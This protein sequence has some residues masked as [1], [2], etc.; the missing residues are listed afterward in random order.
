MDLIHKVYDLLGW[1]VA[2]I[3]CASIAMGLV[4]FGADLA[5]A[6]SLQALFYSMNLLPDKPAL[7]QDWIPYDNLVFVLT[8]FLVSGTGRG[9]VTWAQT[10]LTGIVI[11]DFESRIRSKLINWAFADR[12]V[13]VGAIADLFN[14]KTIGASNFI[15]SLL[16]SVETWVIRPFFSSPQGAIRRR[17]SLWRHC[18]PAIKVLIRCCWY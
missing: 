1:R 7:F 14:D 18:T 11:I 8:L 9:L 15:S 6:F 13:R 2:L 17:R 4:M 12:S 10:Y 5:L 16:N 3:G